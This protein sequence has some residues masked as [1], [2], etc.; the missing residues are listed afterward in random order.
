MLA[1]YYSLI[2]IQYDPCYLFGCASNITALSDPNSR[3]VLY[4]RNYIEEIGILRV[5]YYYGIL[6][7]LLYFLLVMRSSRSV[8]LPAMYFFTVI[9]YPVVYG[10]LTTALL[11]LSINYFNNSIVSQTMNRKYN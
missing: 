8:A 3:Y 11:A 9:H 10:V 2:D 1:V 7:L 5:I 6:W 4:S